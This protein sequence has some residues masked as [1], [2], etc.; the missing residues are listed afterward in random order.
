MALLK[1]EIDSIPKAPKRFIVPPGV[2][3]II[4][5]ILL[6]VLPILALVWH[7]VKWRILLSRLESKD[8]ST[9]LA[10]ID[11]MR[12]YPAYEHIKV[13]YR[14]WST[15]PSRT[16]A[17]NVESDLSR[18]LPKYEL[19]LGKKYFLSLVLEDERESFAQEV[20]AVYRTGNDDQRRRALFTLYVF[21]GRA[22]EDT[23][24][25][26]LDDQAM[27]V[28]FV[29]RLCLVDIGTYEVLEEVLLSLRGEEH[30]VIELARDSILG[31]NYGEF[32]PLL[33]AKLGAKAGEDREKAIEL[34]KILT[35]T[36]LGFKAADPPEKRKAA[37]EKWKKYIGKPIEKSTPPK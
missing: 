8:E 27:Q 12:E 36:T 31:R 25:R 15:T 28:R 17:K 37:I 2:G 14:I 30:A 23:L 1:S 6:G 10:A 26:A 16:V 20:E 24:F 19:G 33:V 35:G 11:E 29:A 4:T 22:L 34:L 5:L 7:P 21:R 3:C 18:G 9:V 13:F 32:F